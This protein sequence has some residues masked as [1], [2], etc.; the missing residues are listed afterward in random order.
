MQTL[1]YTKAQAKQ[2]SNKSGAALVAALAAT[3][4]L[5]LCAP[6]AG[7]AQGVHVIKVGEGGS[8]P[9]VIEPAKSAAAP[10]KESL[11][12]PNKSASGI[13]QP[14]P[15]E[16]SPF[17]GQSGYG[18]PRI[19]I[20]CDVQGEKGRRLQ[21]SALYV[22]AIQRAGGLPF[23]VPPMSADDLYW[24]HPDGVLM[25][26][27]DDY[28]PESYGQT[29]HPS[30]SIMDKA[31]SD[32]D[33][34]LIK[35]VRYNK[36]LPFLGICAGCQALNIGSGGTLT[37]DIPSQKPESKVMH[38]SPD[39]WQKGFNQHIVEFKPDSKL[40]KILDRTSE[41]E[42]TSH[43]QCV[44]KLGENLKPIASTADGVVEGVEM[45][46]RDFGIG[47][48]FHPERAFDKNEKL[49]KEFVHQADL[50]RSSR[51]H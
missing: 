26:G 21:V 25:I 48:Q 11:P 29:P 9:G 51:V 23:I 49:F 7:L 27:G 35:Y 41:T 31:R 6:I 50:Y 12:V 37:Q 3:I 32:F 17:L 5:N 47:V 28:P 8:V 19:L 44:D 46:D 24:M 34:N 13:V 4:A 38:A 14:P 39:G 45:T 43:H 22:E 18:K 15:P 1:S 10:S 30:V 16:G 36:G 2:S 42:P 33:L 20:N 40:A